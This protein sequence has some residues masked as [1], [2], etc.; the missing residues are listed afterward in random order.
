MIERNL[1]KER[2]DAVRSSR[3]R[4]RQPADRLDRQGEVG[5]SRV[6]RPDQLH[7]EGGIGST[8]ELGRARVAEPVAAPGAHGSHRGG[9][10]LGVA[11]IVALL[12]ITT[13][14]HRT[15][16]DLIHVGRSDFGVFQ[17]EVSDLS[18]SLLPESIAASSRAAARCRGGREGEAARRPRAPR[19]RARPGRVRVQAPRRASA[20]SA[21]RRSPATARATD[22]GDTVAVGGRPFTVDGVYHSGDRFEDLGFV[23][24]LRRARGDRAAAARDHD[25]RRRRR[26]RLER[27]GRRA[28][29]SSGASRD[30]PRSP[31]PGRR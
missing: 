23:A 31:S 21:G 4:R 3:P 28:A 7:Q 19:V 15:A 29:T 20:A 1:K 10:R 11:L 9:R 24:P 5:G 22:V 13:G 25:D 6:G 2:H 26:A 16:D 8:R 17:G 14:V 12:A 30:S 27:H 18:R